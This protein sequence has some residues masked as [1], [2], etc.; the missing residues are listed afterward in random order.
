MSFI[1][2]PRLLLRTWLPADVEPLAEIYGDPEVTRYLPFGVRS[3]DQTREAIAKMVADYEREGESLWPVVLKESGVL[4]GAC[5]LMGARTSPEAEL[6]FAFARAAWGHG[7][8][9]EA[10]HATLNFGFSALGKREIG[11]LVQFE[12]KRCIELMHRLEMRFDRVVRANRA[13]LLRYVKHA[14]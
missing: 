12:N 6:G 14:P 5:G 9:L 8:A 4:I 13:D 11:A 3:I 7:Y 10:A 2:T 1:E